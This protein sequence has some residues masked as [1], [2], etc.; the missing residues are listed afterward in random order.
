MLR[1]LAQ[2][3]RGGALVGRRGLCT[4][5]QT[6]V[7]FNSL[8]DCTKEDMDVMAAEYVGYT[9]PQHLTRRCIAMLE[10]S[11]SARELVAV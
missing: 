5:A 1:V 10:V 9:T 4:T 2:V 3:S 11:S 8:A 6:G 7:N